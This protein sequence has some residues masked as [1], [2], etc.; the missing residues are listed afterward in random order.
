MKLSVL[1]YELKNAVGFIT[2][3]APAK[4]GLGD[5]TAVKLKAVKDRQKLV[6]TVNVLN[7][8]ATIPVRATIEEE[9][10]VVIRVADLKALIASFSSV[11]SASKEEAAVIRM[12][13]GGSGIKFRAKA[14]KP[15]GKY[16]SIVRTVSSLHKEIGAVRISQSDDHVAVKAAVLLEALHAITPSLSISTS[17][18]GFSGVLF[19]SDG[20]YLKIASTNSV[21]LSECVIELDSPVEFSAVIPNQYIGRLSASLAKVDKNADVRIRMT[22]KMCVLIVGSYKIALPLSVDPFPTYSM[23][24]EA[25]RSFFVVGTKDFV[26]NLRSI[27]YYTNKDD[28][29][30]LSIKAI[31]SELTL[32][33]SSGENEAISV[34]HMDTKSLHIDVDANLMYSIVSKIPSD[35]TIVYYSDSKSPLVVK[36]YD[37]DVM[38]CSYILAPLR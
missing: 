20:K 12:S 22:E 16:S 36:P 3:F 24:L 35:N 30:R 28:N 19:V 4:D 27:S 9:G 2:T 26:D 7:N 25:T 29:N 21:T 1:F 5:H 38:R 18:S 37:Y 31:D 23:L 32:F 15:N 33:T 13:V 34:E 17:I 14:R 11:L 8:I 10:S 6:F